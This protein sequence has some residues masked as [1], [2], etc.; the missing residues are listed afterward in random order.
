MRESL[1]D[2]LRLLLAALSLAGLGA[3]QLALPWVIKGWVE[4]PLANGVAAGTGRFA[5]TAAAIAAAVAVLLLTSR[6]LL[7]GHQRQAAVQVGTAAA[8]DIALAQQRRHVTGGG[9]EPQV[10]AT[11]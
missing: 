3:A 9:G 4:G 8:Q 1:R 10:L 7:A 2:P 6:T 5:L 11:Q